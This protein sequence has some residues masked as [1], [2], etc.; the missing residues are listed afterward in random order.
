M[1]TTTTAPPTLAELQA[2]AEAT[3][4]RHHGY[5]P[6]WTR[7][8]AGG[9]GL[10]NCTRPLGHPRDWHAEVRAP[11]LGEPAELSGTWPVVSTW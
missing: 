9:P 2:E 3:P 8:P 5:C 10:L 1:T 6:S 7:H 4:A 11:G